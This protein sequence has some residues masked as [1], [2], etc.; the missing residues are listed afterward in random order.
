MTEPLFA[1]QTQ[2]EE[3]IGQGSVTFADNILTL[4][5]EGRSY[6]MVPAAL[7]TTLIDGQDTLELLGRIFRVS[8]LEEKGV[9]VFHDSLIVDD[10]AY[11]CEPGFVGDLQQTAAEEDVFELTDVVSPAAAPQNPPPLPASKPVEDVDLL[12]DFFLKNL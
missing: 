1:S 7:V 6:L 9:E 12:T 11:Q 5:E 8:E 2:L 10:T 3:W 4:V